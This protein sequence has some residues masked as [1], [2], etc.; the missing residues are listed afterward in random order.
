MTPARVF[1][2]DDENSGGERERRTFL[3]CR[4]SLIGLE[5]NGVPTCVGAGQQADCKS[6]YSCSRPVSGPTGRV[7]LWHT[8]R[9][10]DFSEQHEQAD[11]LPST[12]EHPEE[13]SSAFIGRESG[14]KIV[15]G[16]QSASL[17]RSRLSSTSFPV[18]SRGR[19]KTI[20][21]PSQKEWNVRTCTSRA[22]QIFSSGFFLSDIFIPL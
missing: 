4:P 2:N 9:R 17:R 8:A 19:A 18:F 1:R 22:S 21:W 14:C 11:S 16:S 6:A 15:K 5:G 20:A 10:A 12:A 13:R 7:Q 3:P